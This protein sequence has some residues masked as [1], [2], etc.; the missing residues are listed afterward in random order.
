MSRRVGRP[1]PPKFRTLAGAWGSGNGPA[2]PAG[3]DPKG[4]GT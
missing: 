1:S 4:K 2:T 3:Q